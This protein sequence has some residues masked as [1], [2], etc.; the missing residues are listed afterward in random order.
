MRIWC[1]NSVLFMKAVFAFLLALPIGSAS[2]WSTKGG[3]DQADDDFRNSDDIQRFAI[4]NGLWTPDP[5]LL[6]GPYEEEAPRSLTK[7]RFI[8]ANNTVTTVQVGAPAA[9]RCQISNVASHET[10]S[11]IRRRDHH[12]ITLGYQ[13]YTNDDRFYVSNSLPLQ[14]PTFEGK[15]RLEEWNLHIKYAQVRDSGTYECQLSAHPPI[16]ILASLNVI[17]TMSEITGAPDFYAQEGS[18]VTLW[19]RLRHFTEPPSYVFW[20]HGN[21]MINYNADEKITVIS[22]GGE[23]RLRIQKVEKKAS[24]NYTC[25]PANARP[26]FIILH[27]IT[28]ETPAAMQRASAPPLDSAFTLGLASIFMLLNGL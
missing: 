11:W 12:L 17:E 19:C 22:Q 5:Q 24:G 10:V 4:E 14:L 8:T 3:H 2:G 21:D 15:V 6:L 23:S 25:M 7:A 18:D 13:T 16:G 28:G 20:Y 26:S 1:E 27:V 9:L